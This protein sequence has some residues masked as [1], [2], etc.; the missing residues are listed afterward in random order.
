M[1]NLNREKTIFL[2]PISEV[3]EG[4]AKAV[5]AVIINFE[6]DEP[7]RGKVRKK[8]NKIDFALEFF[9]RYNPEFFSKL[10]QQDIE[11]L[12]NSLAR[13]SEFNTFDLICKFAGNVSKEGLGLKKDGTISKY[14]GGPT[15]GEFI[16]LAVIHLWKNKLVLL[17][18]SVSSPQVS[19]SSF[20]DFIYSLNSETLTEIWN[21]HPKSPNLLNVNIE[22]KKRA[23]TASHWCRFILSTEL[24]D[25]S[26][27][28][29]DS[30]ETILDLKN[31][32]FYSRYYLQQFLT[33]IA[34]LD[35]T[36]KILE[37]V[38]D[39]GTAREQYLKE[40][41][42]TP[43][44]TA[45]I[46]SRKPRTKSGESM[47][48][49]RDAY[50]KHKDTDLINKA[51]ARFRYE[52]ML[53]DFAN[54][55]DFL[56]VKSFWE[57]FYKK[58][59]ISKSFGMQDSDTS[60]H[61]VYSHLDPTV[62]NFVRLVWLLFGSLLKSKRNE[63]DKDIVFTCNLLLA[64]VAFF[65]P[66]FLRNRDGDLEAYPKNFNEFECGI[67]IVRDEY[68]EQLIHG[69][70][71]LPPTVFN[72]LEGLAES[73]DWIND[74]HYS[75]ALQIKHF[76]EHVEN[77][78]SVVP[79]SDKF[80]ST[81]VRGDMP[82]TSKRISTVKKFLP[83]EYFKTF[84]SMLESLDYLTDHL[85]SMANQENPVI[86]NGKLKYVSHYDLH[87]SNF[88]QGLWGKYGAMDPYV[89][90][91]LL[92][93]TPIIYHDGKCYPIN[94]IRRFYKLDNFQKNGK[95]LTRVIPH[96]SRISLLMCHTGI[97]QHHL[98]W[99]DKDRFD[100]AVRDG[101][102]VLNPL[103]VS[104]DKAHG[105]WISIV[106]NDVIEL[107]RKQRKWYDECESEDFYKVVWY[108][109]NKGSKF[110]QFKPLF[111]LNSREDTWDMFREFPKLLLT[112]Q[113][114]LKDQ[115]GIEDLPDLVK[116][117]PTETSKFKGRAREHSITHEQ[118]EKG[119]YDASWKFTLY[120]DYT[121]HGLRSAFVSDAIRFLP[122]SLI[123]SSLTG[124]TEKLVWY[125]AIFDETGGKD[126]FE[127]LLDS[128]LQNHDDIDAV[129]APEISKKIAMLN[130]KLMKQVKANPS[131]AIDDFNLVSLAG[132][133]EEKCGIQILRAKKSAAL[134]F[135][136][137][138]ICPFN[139]TC[140]TEVIKSFGLGK[141]CSLCPYAVRGK[142]HLPAVNAEKFK[143]IELM[144]EYAIKLRSYQKRPDTAQM[145]SDK[146]SLE[147]NLD[148]T[149]REAAAL[150]AIE[151]Q[152]LL[153]N[154][155]DSDDLIIQEKDTLIGFYKATEVSEPEYLMKRLIDAQ[156]IPDITTSSVQRKFARFR[157]RL[158]KNID[159][160]DSGD[161]S[162]IE[163]HIQLGAL[164][165]SICTVS[166][167]SIKDVY[168]LI[169][170]EAEIPSLTSQI[171]STLGLELK[172]PKEILGE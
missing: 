126:H 35:D 63:R 83:R 153:L 168:K 44:R 119:D 123:G 64:Y 124:Q 95:T 21:A 101:Y 37:Q 154:N 5:N 14:R 103:L 117:V 145:L 17:P 100:L 122:P 133:T 15:V 127:M 89:D 87:Q 18:L 88:F 110:G 104:T 6:A 107:C 161:D 75:R 91:S 79:D 58:L 3:S 171:S 27:I 54:G 28:T 116:W 138:H 113:I 76:C 70:T 82:L 106:S 77:N 156:I 170:K 99:L 9:L 81:I 125:Y 143:Q 57:A 139:N 7:K 159:L 109:H 53:I 169:K 111:R 42:K 23:K 157:Y 162:E 49:N 130:N 56:E 55:T 38:A 112:L 67:Y 108:N 25:S 86:V 51:S 26:C 24:Y 90:T 30:I 120:S 22:E 19:R 147:R 11:I 74:T 160:I 150:E 141:P 172:K 31:D 68:V 39:Y 72:F 10:Q 98:I 66:V 61:F 69:D 84:I 97:R 134:A 40:S 131:D 85:N 71:K 115:L 36:G 165:K 152:L 136:S 114:F 16:K 33:I 2:K 34:S 163:E 78:N 155:N 96:A 8:W 46:S 105:E 1:I 158:I 48:W 142:M 60:S 151:Q 146:E 62:Q 132:V 45:P 59:W 47:H 43:V 93:Y 92:N 135:N 29:Q 128:V 13:A 102:Q 166:N 12:I 50:I 164:L 118:Y 80:T 148:F 121:P 149:T 144:K 129:G 137:T 32:S 41:R 167:L 73:Q 4:L 52:N 20:F 140:P 94:R 65:L